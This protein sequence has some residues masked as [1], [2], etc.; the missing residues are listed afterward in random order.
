[1]EIRRAHRSDQPQGRG[2]RSARERPALRRRRAAV[3]ADRAAAEEGEGSRTDRRA[4]IQRE[5]PRA[6]RA[7][8]PARSHRKGGRQ[9][10]RIGPTAPEPSPNPR[11]NWR[12]SG[13]TPESSRSSTST[14]AQERSTQGRDTPAQRPPGSPTSKD[15]RDRRQRQVP[16]L[17]RRDHGRG[18]RDL[19][20][21]RG[22]RRSERPGALERSGA[23]LQDRRVPRHRQGGRPTRCVRHH[24][25]I[26][27]APGRRLRRRV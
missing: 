6:R 15:T 10:P 27:P 11:G 8:V 22:G 24:S 17:R 19:D 26:Q 1:M 7:A 9:R 12:R 21:I 23:L 2:Q 16:R 25:A 14:S 18:T 4:L 13:N 5:L 20:R 3:S